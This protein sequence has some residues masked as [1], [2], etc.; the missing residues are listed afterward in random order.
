MLIDGHVHLEKGKLTKEYVFEFINQAVL[1]GLDELQILDHSHRFKEFKPLYEYWLVNKPQK[2]WLSLKLNDSLDDYCALINEVKKEKLPIKVT[3]GLEICYEPE[4]EDLIKKILKPYH[5]DFLVGAIHTINYVAYDCKWSK[6]YLW[7]KYPTDEIYQHYYANM[8]KL[9]ESNIFTQLAHPDTIKMFN[10]YPT[11]DL[12][13]T[14][15]HLADLCVTHHIKVENNV[16]CY[17][18]YHHPDLG[19]SKELLQIFKEH[20]CDII[21]ATD[22]HLPNDVGKYI[23]EVSQ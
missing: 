8:F 18:R 2:E 6:E 9:V 15:Q 16:G 23:K 4:Q 13:S 10:Y 22:A 12:T 7:E 1:M 3:F 17:Y 21:T 14:Y 5:F 11:Y 19:L 20:H